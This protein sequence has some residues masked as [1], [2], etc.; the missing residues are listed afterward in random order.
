VGIDGRDDVV[1]QM[2]LDLLLSPVV[3]FG[4]SVQKRMI[5]GATMI[6]G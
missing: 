2:G 4:S 5:R 1:E 3:A 6:A